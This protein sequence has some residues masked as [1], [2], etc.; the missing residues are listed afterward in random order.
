[1][2]TYYL[3]VDAVDDCIDDSANDYYR[4]ARNLRSSVISLGP[5]VFNP[6]EAT[7]KALEN[8]LSSAKMERLISWNVDLLL[9]LLTQSVARRQILLRS[10]PNRKKD[11]DESI[12]MSR[13]NSLLDEVKETI[14]MP[15]DF[16]GK[17]AIEH[18]KTIR[19]DPAVREQLHDYVRTVA[20]MVSEK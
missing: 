5:G 17:E 7:S 14:R 20:N 9:R 10:D 12:Y 1:M 16:H 3:N 8:K 13:E 2:Q 19:L 15:S 4:K 18:A 6:T 11:A